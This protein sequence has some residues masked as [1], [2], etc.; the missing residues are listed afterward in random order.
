MSVGVMVADRV[1]DFFF[2]KQAENIPQIQTKCVVENDWVNWREAG[3]RGVGS[4][5]GECLL[6]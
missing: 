4:K 3:E 6:W 2:S 5:A 1:Y